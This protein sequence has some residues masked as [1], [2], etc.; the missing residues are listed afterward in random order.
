MNNIRKLCNATNL[1]YLAIVSVIAHLFD[2]TTVQW[3]MIFAVIPMYFY[4]GERGS[5]NKNFFYI[6]YPAHIYLLWILASFFQI[7]RQ[8]QSLYCL[9]SCSKSNFYNL[10]PASK[11]AII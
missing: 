2:P 5:G 8:R 3:M 6:F 11:T 10:F 7:R 1:K 9:F 4:N